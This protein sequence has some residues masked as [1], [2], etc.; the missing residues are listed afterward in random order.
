MSPA[1]GNLWQQTIAQASGLGMSKGEMFMKSVF[2]S[3]D[4]GAGMRRFEGMD[5]QAKQ[6]QAIG[7]LASQGL[8]PEQIMQ[9][10]FQ[11]GAVSDPSDMIGMANVGISRQRLGVDQLNAGVG[12]RRQLH[13]EQIATPEYRGRVAGA[14]EAAKAPY[15]EPKPL[16]MPDGSTIYWQPGIG[17]LTGQQGEVLRGPT[18][19]DEEVDKKTAAANVAEL[20]ELTAAQAKANEAIMTNSRM[21]AVLDSL[22][23]GATGFGGPQFL[24]AQKALMALTGKSAAEVSSMGDVAALEEL[25]SLQI[26]AGVGMHKEGT[27]PMD[28]K[29]QELYMQ[30]VAGLDNTVQGNK[31]LV[32]YSLFNNKRALARAQAK[33]RW[34]FA[35]DPKTGRPRRNFRGFNESWD[36]YV[37][38]RPAPWMPK[39]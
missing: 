18:T 6:A 35:E 23:E 20:G 1:V 10:M 21:K 22:P 15:G 7:M 2:S 4:T 29:E 39:E 26:Q 14:E 30:S 33:E 17:P 25:R 12:L 3:G 37:K 38:S 34:F 9:A 16:A 24:M 8:S 27:G 13:D 36:K 5:Q 28:R 32:A 11:G 31:N 19:F